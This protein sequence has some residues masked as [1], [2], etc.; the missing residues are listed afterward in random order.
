MGLFFDVL[1]SI[2]NPNQGG[3]VEQLGQI[4]NSINELA[5]SN[6]LDASKM[7]GM[8]SS[9][10]PMLRPMLQEQMTGGNN[11]LEGMM[12][13]LPGGGNFDLGGLQ[14]MIPE[15]LQSQMIGTLAQKTGSD[16]SV[17]QSMLPKLLPAVMGLLNMGKTTGGMGGGNPLL[18][19]FLD[20]DRD[21]DTDLGDVF[22]L[23]NRF[24]NPMK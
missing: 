11:P 17:V 2:N 21:G 7:Q 14:S 9:L 1:S 3:S 20:S 23:A 15:Q 10:G 13:Q 24:I 12:G 18:K 5:T 6:G 4:T 8:M 19:A 22:R 16:S